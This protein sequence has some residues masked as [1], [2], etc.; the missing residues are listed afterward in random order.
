L[1]ADSIHIPEGAGQRH[2]DKA[3]ARTRSKSI[4]IPPDVLDA[5]RLEVAGDTKEAEIRYR[6]IL[7][8]RPDQSHALH[9]L[10][11]ICRERGDYA[12]ALKLFVASIK[13][14]RG[15][16]EALSNCG[17]VL[18]DMKRLEEALGYF[19]RALVLQPQNLIALYNRGHALVMLGRENEALRTLDRVLAIEPTHVDALY[20]RATALRELHRHDEALASYARALELAP[21]R[22]DIHLDDALT[23]LR[24]GDFRSGWSRYEWRW[25]KAE[26]QFSQ[27]I[28]DGTRAPGAA[29]V[30]L[31]SKLVLLHAEQGNGDTIQFMRY[32][33]LVTRRGAR[34]VLEVQPALKTLATSVAGV[35]RVIAQGDERPLV[36]LHCPLLSLPRAFGTDLT[37]IPAD[38][39]YIKAPPD[40]VAAWQEE[41][42]GNRRRVGIAWAGNPTY[43]GDRHR[44]IPFARIASLLGAIELVDSIEF[45]GLQREV[46]SAEAGAVAD[47]LRNLGDALTDFAETAAVMTQLELVITVDTAVAHLAG[48]LGKPVW[49]L[50]PR[51]SDFRWLLNRDDSPWYPTARLFRQEKVGDWSPVMAR[52]RAELAAFTVS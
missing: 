40:R 12:E 1:R 21:D 34:V 11:L 13:A 19:D 18:L 27:P 51:S 44:S 35:G 25:R 2:Q 7:T 32:A 50:L 41:L 4:E 24:L 29:E 30:D 9:Q 20:A 3:M 52:V 47:T 5:Y 36:D 31:C 26:T 37:S 15:S 33:P 48:A 43:A 45:V 42:S 10:G 23:R 17:L 46:A 38:V 8:T 28:W 14:N 6:T 22:A 39:P 16:A 49:I